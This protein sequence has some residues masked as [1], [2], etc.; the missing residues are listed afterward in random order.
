[1]LR[2]IG[3]FASAALVLVCLTSCSQPDT[4][5]ESAPPGSQL[6]QR[7][8]A[9]DLSDFH[10]AY[11]GHVESGILLQRRTPVTFSGAGSVALGQP[12][13]AQLEETTAQCESGCQT[14]LVVVGE[15]RYRRNLGDA[16]WWVDHG[17]PVDS[18][19]WTRILPSRLA[20]ASSAR[21]VGQATVK[22]DPAWII[23]GTDELGYPFLVWLRKSD[24]YPLRYESTPNQKTN[25]LDIQITL[26]HF[27]TGVTVT[28][29]RQDQLSPELWGTSYGRERSIPLDG[30][31]VTVHN[32][33]FDC[34]GGEFVDDSRPDTYPVLVP[35]TYA[36]GGSS[37]AVDPRVWKV[38]D[39]SRQ[40][41]SPQ[42]IGSAAKLQ[43]QSLPAAGTSSGSLCFLI[44][45]TQNQVTLIGNLAS[46]L[47]SVYL[48]GLRRPDQ[49]GTASPTG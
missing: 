24:S 10:L 28:P 37:L 27:N 29:P 40:P 5:L 19:L 33:I 42:T 43:A 17:T 7:V 8:G 14:E 26:D 1:M 3:A 9:L 48:G 25:F 22:G 30:G 32:P 41:Y 18:Y 45:W 39:D 12:L 31:G 34:D 13:K 38:Y 46:G 49:T 35:F 21:V 36:A 47:V 44:P 6:I 23:E 4:S 20:K 16:S 15:D 11:T 2:P